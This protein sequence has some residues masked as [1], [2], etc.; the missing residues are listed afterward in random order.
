[1][2]TLEKKLERTIGLIIACLAVAALIFLPW[3][4]TLGFILGGAISS[5]NF[6]FLKRDLKAL[7]LQTSHTQPIK[8]L[9]YFYLR[10]ILT[11]VALYFIISR[12]VANVFGLIF[13]LSLVLIG[14]VFAILWEYRF[15]SRLFPRRSG[16]RDALDKGDDLK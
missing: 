8:L 4:F 3:N 6:F 11:G 14:I 10:L 7:L 2:Q 9:V 1:M 12:E 13:G 16:R 5:L 15:F